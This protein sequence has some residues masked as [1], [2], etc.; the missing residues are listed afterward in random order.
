VVIMV[1]PY[2]KAKNIIW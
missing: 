1:L 2:I